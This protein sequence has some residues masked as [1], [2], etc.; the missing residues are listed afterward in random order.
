MIE[1]GGPNPWWVAPPVGRLFLVLGSKRVSK[2]PMAC[3]AWFVTHTVLWPVLQAVTSRSCIKLLSWILEV[4]EYDLRAVNRNKPFPPQVALG[5]AVLS[6]Q[7]NPYP[8][9]LGVQ[10]QGLR[11]YFTDPANGTTEVRNRRE[12]H[13][14]SSEVVNSLEGV[15]VLSVSIH[16]HAYWV[17]KHK[18]NC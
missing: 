8:W 18:A 14:A 6:Q 12:T 16:I 13:K 17:S 11:Q 9:Q 2:L 4:V 7:Q 3:S 5:Q 10:G 15:Y 1:V